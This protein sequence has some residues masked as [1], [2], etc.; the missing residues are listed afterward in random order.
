MSRVMTLQTHKA[1]VRVL[2]ECM[3]ANPQPDLARMH[4]AAS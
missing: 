4:E 1:D 3:L 2:E